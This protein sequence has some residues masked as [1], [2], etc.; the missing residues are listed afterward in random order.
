VWRSECCDGS[1]THRLKSSE[2]VA[3]LTLPLLGS[4]LSMDGCGGGD[5]KDSDLV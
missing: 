2:M 1:I 4:L 3:R 5:P